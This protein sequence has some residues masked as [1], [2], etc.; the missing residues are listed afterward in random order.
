MELFMIFAV[1]AWLLFMLLSNI[2]WSGAIFLVFLIFA[3][4]VYYRLTIGV[5][6]RLEAEKRDQMLKS[7]M[8]PTS[9]TRKFVRRLRSRKII[10]KPVY[11]D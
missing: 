8:I 1:F 10:E 11:E 9:S 3:G 7:Q 6:R 5:Q 2:T 4:F